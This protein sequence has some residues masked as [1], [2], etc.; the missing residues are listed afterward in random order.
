[1]R[2]LNR[3]RLNLVITKDFHI[4]HLQYYPKRRMTQSMDQKPQTSPN[5]F[6]YCHFLPQIRLRVP[7]TIYANIFIFI[8]DILLKEEEEGMI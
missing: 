5:L 3:I 2:L 7:P 4:F 1:M 8:G 6:H